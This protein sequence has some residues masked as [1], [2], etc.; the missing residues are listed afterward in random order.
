MKKR[1]LIINSNRVS[2]PY[3]VPPLGAA[4]LYRSLEPYY[5]LSF[6]DGF[7]SNLSELANHI[8]G[9]NPDYIAVSIRNIDDMVKAEGLSFVPALEEKFFS[10]IREA[11]SGPVILGGAGFSIF[12]GELMKLSGADYG[13]IGEAE[14]LLVELL[15]C[16]DR[17]RDP[18]QLTGI[19]TK[20]EKSSSPPPRKS[21]DLQQLPHADLDLL[22]DYTPYIKRGAYPV[23]TKRGCAHRCIYCSYPHLEGRKYRRRPP[24]NVVDEI[25]ET[26]Q[27]L[28]GKNITF[29]FVDS[30]FNDPVGHGESI[31]REIIRRDLSVKLRTMG[32]N[33]ANVTSELLDLMQ[34]AGF[35]QIDSTPDSASPQMLVNLKKNFSRK[36]LEQSGALIRQHQMPTMWFFLFG[37]PGE[38]EE[39]FY[40]TVD[41]IEHHVHPEDLVHMTE[42]LRVYP[43]TALYDHALAKG[44]LNAG[45]NLLTPY[46]YISP[47][48]GENRLEE[49]VCEVSRSHVNCI[50]ATE[51]TPP[52]E[53]MAAAME[54]RA[55]QNLDEPMFRT[56]LRLERRWKEEGKR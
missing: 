41:F 25:E 13:I 12:P 3:P 14:L 45:D 50:R 34:E 23:Q 7:C 44:V 18:A 48:I 17:G 9:F 31:C 42:G 28:T 1:V 39:T 29:E 4:L 6:F 37:G 16:L 10:P 15:D 52:P 54:Q 46:Y 56:L 30:T 36:Q 32:I 47:E 51:S 19:I 53:L 27:R 55:A 24:E 43:H 8:R 49:L 40:E 11:F 20:T 2:A 22:L 33:P 21:V 5:H 38:T 35:S 26:S